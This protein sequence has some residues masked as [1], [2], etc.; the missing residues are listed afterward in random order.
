M[1]SDIPEKARSQPQLRA[2]IETIAGRL[3][4]FPLRGDS[5]RAESNPKYRHQ[6]SASHSSTDRRD[7]RKAG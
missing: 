3:V 7:L 1:R 4:A 2:I 5:R 6:K